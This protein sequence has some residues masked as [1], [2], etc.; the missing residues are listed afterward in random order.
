MIAHGEIGLKQS[1]PFAPILVLRKKLFE[2][3]EDAAF[4]YMDELPEGEE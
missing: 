2:G 4:S 1:S 3:G